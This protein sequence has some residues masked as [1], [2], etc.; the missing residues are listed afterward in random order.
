[1]EVICV[2][3]CLATFDYIIDPCF[4]VFQY[5]F[6]KSEFKKKNL[7]ETYNQNNSRLQDKLEAE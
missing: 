6:L 4:N 5:F 2:K 1:M 3:L 7:D